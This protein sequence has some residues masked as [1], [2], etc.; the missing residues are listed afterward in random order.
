MLTRQ[1]SIMLKR[2]LPIF[3]ILLLLLS[4][5]AATYTHLLIKKSEEET[6]ENLQ[7]ISR[8]K[9]TQI[10]NWLKERD[11]DATV[12]MN[13]ANLAQR[14]EQYIQQQKA[15]D[16]QLLINHMHS[17]HQAYGYQSVLL[18]DVHG[19]LLLG[20]GDALD[21]PDSIKHLARQSLTHRRIV[22][23]DLYRETSGHIHM[24]WIAPI[25]KTDSADAPVIAHM[26]L[27]VN[28]K[29]NLFRIFE[30]WP[31]VSASGESFL[32]RKDGDAILALSEL[33]HRTSSALQ[34]SLPLSVPALPA[35]AAIKTQLPGTL[36]GKDYRGIS[37]LSAYQPVA[38]T[39]W[40]IVAKIDRS[41]I[42]SH[43]WVGL[44]WILSISIAAIVIILG[45]IWRLFVQQAR[46][47]TMALEVKQHQVFQQI[48]SL[49][50]NLPN[51]FVFQFE[52]MPDGQF[53]FNYISAGVKSLLGFSPEQIV[54]DTSLLMKNLDPDYAEKYIAEVEKS[55]RELSNFS[56]E[57]LFSTKNQSKVWLDVHSRPTRANNGHVIW[58]GVAL[59]I[60]ERKHAEARLARLNKFYAALTKIGEAIFY[61]NDENQLFREICTI[62][63]NSGVMAMSW[64]G[65]ED[66]A[67]ERILP[68]IKY[69]KGLDY[70]DDIFISTREDLA[71]GRGIVGT[72]WREQK[73]AINN[74]TASNPAMTPWAARG[75]QYG[76]GSSAALPIFRNRQIYAVF[77]CYHT[78]V[79]IFDDEIISLLTSMVSDISYALDNIDAKVALVASENRFRK[80][81]NDSKQPMMLVADGKFIDANQATLALMGIDSLDTFK[82]IR[83]EDISPEYQPDGT[84]SSAKIADVF[85]QAL[86]NGSNRFEWEHI[87][88]NGEHFM[89]E[90]MLTPIS[91]AE[92]QILH[93]VWTDITERIRL[94]EQ[95]KQYKTIVES[96][97]DA[98]ISKSSEGY[99]TSWNP[100]AENMFGYPAE[101]MLGTTL[102]KL[103][104]PDR[105]DEEDLILD[106]I[107]R[108]EVVE[109]FE[110]ERVRKD[111]TH[112]F[113]SVT[114]SPIYDTKGQIVGASKVARDI[115]E[116]KH[117]E[118][119]L[120][121]YRKNLEDLVETRTA[122]VKAAIAQIRIS[123]QRYEFA[124]N[125]TND[126]LWDW[127][128][129][130]G[131]V[132]YNASYFRML[133]YLPEDFPQ[134]TAS[135]VWL[136]LLHPE[137]RNKLAAETQQL[138]L[139]KG[140][141]DCEFRM[142]CKD[143][144]YKWILS[145]GK[146]VAWDNDNTPLRAVGTHVDQTLRKQMEMALLDAKAKAE[147][148]NHAKSAFLA[149]MS[150]EIRTPMNAI[151]GF[152]HLLERDIRNPQ[153]RDMLQ[154]IKSSS[155]HLLGL[156]NDILDLSK[157]EAEHLTLETLPFNAGATIAH[158]C[159]MMNERLEAKGLTMV[160]EVDPVLLDMPLLGDP[161]RIGQM[162]INYVGNAIK[163]T[164][165]G[166]ITLRAKIEQETAD[167]VLLRFEVEDTG[168]GIS[169]ENQQKLFHEFEQA[170]SSTTRKYGGTGLGLAINQRLA[171]LMHGNVGVSSR[172]GQG[173]LF[174]FNIL[175][176][177][178]NPTNQA[179]KAAL[180]HNT[181]RANALILLVEDSEINQEVAKALLEDIHL[182]VD[183]ANNGA[184]AV[185]MAQEQRYDLILMDM[186]MPV[187]DGLEATEKIRQLDI[188][189]TLPIIAMTANAFIEDR[190]RCLEVGMND[191]VAKPVDPKLLYAKLAEWIPA[192]A[193]TQRTLSVEGSVAAE[194]PALTAQDL[195]PANAYMLSAIHYDTGVAF[196]NGNR[197][198]YHG[199]LRKFKLTYGNTVEKIREYL[200]NADPRSAE[201][202]THTLKGIAATLGIET[203]RD[204]ASAV[205]RTL[206]A[207]DVQQELTKQLDALQQAL[208]SAILEVDMLGL[209][210]AAA[211]APEMNNQQLKASLQALA[212]ALNED[213]PSAADI[214]HEIKPALL[215][216]MNKKAL[217]KLDMLIESY[218]L[219]AALLTLRRILS[220]L[221]LD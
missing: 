170:E 68:F 119:E 78:E 190:Q 37:V 8:L 160:E 67:C 60:T 105:T 213:S 218:D 194:H 145:R 33:R 193:D 69:G 44:K 46:L 108:G 196:F 21:M 157:I 25:V 75:A 159:S 3:F 141:Y 87:R 138:L 123:E 10:S 156:I 175:L 166:Q 197:A 124:S 106:K 216:K 152:T 12:V 126:G 207:T 177:R 110:T 32:V 136:A 192:T 74:N 171:K 107:K 188:G 40:R 203:L 70:L 133:G 36:A 58:D 79:G 185:N 73:P 131:D 155:K 121:T 178:G 5:I 163:F 104:P 47:N 27:R 140:G 91:F 39:E 102:D 221:S 19:R 26:I 202:L 34:F 11:A 187:M 117:Q 191:F 15:A 150:H 50:D 94:Q 174:W 43:L 30:K 101:D 92:K 209:E 112:I 115:T 83:P 59:G 205:E 176:K 129:Q 90:I 162:L 62:T 86:I 88:S 111:G 186:Q 52:K 164:E 151:L 100:A 128:L 144:S 120:D 132:Y 98:I 76:W 158:V 113:V 81:F 48:Q 29:Q 173:S 95:F 16:K 38:G 35:A 54:T 214:W 169:E 153:H 114:V 17:L 2:L 49:G 127:N 184:E 99:V 165:H 118:A 66:K 82:G 161:L 220:K 57:L 51:G 180:K 41:E 134:H 125:A 195:K 23:S 130:T 22:R 13:S 208:T 80:L 96:S 53:R 146:V 72:A 143:G 212:A 45:I 77:S 182:R 183:I 103:L 89:A 147:A 93:V 172:L 204:A 56:M 201:R 1:Q 200:T 109:H 116:K 215:K 142:R 61:A 198:R 122:E 135:A 18:V 148:A 211:A 55:E 219:A 42:L 84:L 206:H 14:I 199:M 85:S 217:E 189:K 167:N 7:S 64:I 139:E 20:V 168:I 9:A 210:E 149:N 181:P 24:D 28:P 71:E 179:L 4:L 6:F 31:T 63:V 137:E 97:N 65:F 154:K